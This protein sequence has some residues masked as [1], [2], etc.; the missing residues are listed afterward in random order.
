MKHRAAGRCP[1]SPKIAFRQDAAER[2]A[3]VITTLAGIVGLVIAL[4]VPTSYLL[5]AYV[6]LTDTLESRTRAY[7]AAVA[8]TAG[9]SPQVWNAFLGNVESDLSRFAIAAADDPRDTALSPEQR[10]VFARDGRIIIDVP[11]RQPL[12]WPVLAQQLPVSENGH[13]MGEV[14]VAR[15]FRPVVVT[16]ALLGAVSL[17]LG[18][19]LI[20]LLRILPLRLMHEALEWARYLSAHDVLTGLPNRAL[21]N[22]RL[23]HS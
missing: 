15:S 20:L 22:D 9:Q 19:V 14:E 10:R 13:R 1:G 17:A 21:F 6:R 7:A 3:D 12:A 2:L 11:P 8:D 16:A 4:A 5:T 18:V 23:E